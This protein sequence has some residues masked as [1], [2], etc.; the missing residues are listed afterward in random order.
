MKIDLDPNSNRNPLRDSVHDWNSRKT[1]LYFESESLLKFPESMLI[2]D[3][4][5]RVLSNVLV[6]AHEGL[7][8]SWSWYFIRKSTNA[9]KFQSFAFPVD[10]PGA[11][12]VYQLY[13]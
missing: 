12:P 8:A 5:G 7:A 4:S 2:K 6:R 3:Y 9:A 11:E 13:R 1:E 10:C